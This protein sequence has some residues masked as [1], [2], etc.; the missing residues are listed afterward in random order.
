MNPSP[1]ETL[2]EDIAT[3]L[4]NL[5]DLQDIPIMT[6]QTGNLQ[7]EIDKAINGLGLWIVV[8]LERARHDGAQTLCPRYEAHITIDVHENVILYQ[9]SEGGKPGGWTFAAHIDAAL[10]QLTMQVGDQSVLLQQAEAMEELSADGDEVLSV[11]LTY[12]TRIA[13]TPRQPTP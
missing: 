2:R 5:A 9:G 8:G 13:G 7:Y 10:Q 11:R 12:K 1:L 6:R 4:G 3:T